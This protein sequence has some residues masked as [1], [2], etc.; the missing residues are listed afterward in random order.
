[1]KDMSRNP[2]LLKSKLAGALNPQM[3]NQLGGM[4]NIMDMVK[5]LG[6]MEKAG[7]LGDLSKMMGGMAAGKK[8]RK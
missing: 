1:M 6:N 5:Q 2:N 8:K 3:M 4:D 7:Q